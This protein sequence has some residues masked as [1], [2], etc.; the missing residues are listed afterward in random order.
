MQKKPGKARQAAHGP[1]T[2]SVVPGA[3]VADGAHILSGGYRKCMQPVPV[4]PA[5]FGSGA[6]CAGQQLPDGPAAGSSSVAASLQEWMQ[7]GTALGTEV[8]SKAAAG[9]AAA[10]AGAAAASSSRRLSVASTGQAG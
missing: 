1:L 7:R 9:A 3:P 8:L 10:A 5:Q 6:A 4:P 2:E